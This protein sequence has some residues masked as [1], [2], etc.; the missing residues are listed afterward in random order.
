VALIGDAASASDPIWGLGLSL[1]SRDARVLSDL[2][3]AN[4]DWDS[5]CHSYA[6]AHDEYFSNLR[7]A[8][9]IMRELLVDRGP[10]ADARR[11][12]ALPRVASGVAQLPDQGFCGPD[13]PFDEAARNRLYGD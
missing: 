2:L 13:Q 7:G 5:A 4:D 6:R 3:R 11:A 9:N 12:K 1:T 8:D 10:E